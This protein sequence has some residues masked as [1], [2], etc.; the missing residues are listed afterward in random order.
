[1]SGLSD[2]SVNAARIARFAFTEMLNNAIDH[3]G[4]KHVQVS[5]TGTPRLV[6]VVSD[7]GV[8]AFEHVRYHHK[9]EDHVAAIQEIS[10][11]KLTTD[12]A[13]HSGQGI[14]FT[15]KAVD[16]FS[17]AS[18]GWRWTVD[19]VRGDEAIARLRTGKGTRVEFEVDPQTSRS[20]K[21]IMDPF[22]DRETF[23][24]STS[25]AVVAL[26]RSDSVFV[27]RAEAKRLI[28]NLDR[29]E[30]I[31]IDFNGVEEIGQGFADEIFRVWQSEHP[32]ARLVP[33]NMNDGVRITVER[34]RRAQS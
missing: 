2:L 24:F 23:E 26:F 18:N 4:S 8:G 1:M 31:I 19:S 25:R 28:R 32:A 27:S 12:P 3:S 22:T 29:F 11:G 14:F 10:K 6:I 30:E 17:L 21:D 20:L 13:R 34:A 16:L 5:V 15:S 7:E 9:L 33:T